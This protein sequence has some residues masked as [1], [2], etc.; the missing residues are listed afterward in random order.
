[1]LGVAGSE[2]ARSFCGGGAGCNMEASFRAISALAT[3]RLHT[4]GD[5]QAFVEGGIG[6]G[7]LISE[8]ADDLFENPAQHG[9]GGAAFLLAGGG[10]W[11][12]ARQMALGFEVA[13]TRWTHVSRPAFTYGVED[14]PAR[15]DLGV[16]ALLL[17]L[18]VGW[19]AGR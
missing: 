6:P 4:A 1:V 17:L 9:R 2:T 13:W 15:S 7:H 18:T 5:W 14:F 8:S 11:F 16:N 19:S 10:R 3:L 12:V